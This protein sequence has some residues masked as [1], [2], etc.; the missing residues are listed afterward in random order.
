M[1]E[2]LKI[3]H[4]LTLLCTMFL[5]PIAFLAYLFVAQ[6][7]KDVVFAEKEIDGSSY[8]NLLRTELNT[9]IDLSQGY[10]RPDDMAAAQKAVLDTDALKAAD[11]NATESAAKAAEAVK[12]LMALPKDSGL[13]A[14][15]AGLDAITDHV[16]KVEDGS[17]LTLDPDLDS[18][19]AQDFVTLKVPAQVVASSR[20]LQN[21]LPMLAGGE[22][23]PEMTVAFLTAKGTYANGLS[24]MDGDLSSGARGNPDGSFK[25]ASDK[26]YADF[27]AKAAAF[28]ALLDAISDPAAAKPSVQQL[29]EAQHALQLSTRVLW[30]AMGIEMDHLLQARIDGLNQRM[31]RN[32]AITAL[33]LL[34][35]ILLAWRMAAS[36][37]RPLALLS[38]TMQSIA[39]GEV[40]LAVPF[41]GRPDEIGSMAKDVEVFRQGLIQAK[42]LAKAKAAEQAAKEARV[43]RLSDLLGDFDG[44]ISQSLES[45]LGSARQVEE[46]AVS[47]AGVTEDTSSKAASASGSSERALTDVQS[48]AAATEELS[49]SIGEINR[50]VSDSTHV[51]QRAR[52][53][54]GSVT[55]LVKG[56]ST[57]MASVG[58]IV[59]Q[60]EAIA[61]QTNL[62]ALNATIE[63]A[64]AGEMGKGFAVVAGE[65]K[66]LANQTSSSTKL[67]Y[68]QISSIQ[69]STGKVVDSITEVASVIAQMD[70]IVTSIAAAVEQQS[71]TTG[72]IARSV[73]HAAVETAEASESVA[74]VQN[75]VLKTRSSGEEVMTSAESMARMVGDIR[76]RI[77]GF[78]SELRTA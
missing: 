4:K 56:L 28:S 74:T 7:Q 63:A 67:I 61:A 9:A 24:G 36:I 20:A 57:E 6:T 23:T 69:A 32:L 53:A 55:E 39:G 50:Q 70:D 5:V 73:S 45:L 76:R 66:H 19:Y 41:T 37:A 30:Q 14:Y 78:L 1:L 59:D 46:C 43:K 48:V 34:V 3:P 65:V 8:F 33:V 35:T 12:A 42:D 22:A 64:R 49:S 13:D 10:A 58:A 17:N 72:E 71:A 16:A 31:Y 52:E 44:I 40:A 47:M 11:M 29:T 21:A 51:T 68:D 26:P 18:Y 75:S 25:P 62:L 54:A 15:D 2:T 60:I 27:Q 77:D 38:G